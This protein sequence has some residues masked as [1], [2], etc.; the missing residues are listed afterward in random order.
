MVFIKVYLIAHMKTHLLT[1]PSSIALAI[2]AVFWG[3][4][5]Q[6]TAPDSDSASFSATPDAVVVL[7]WEEYI[8][9]EVMDLYAEESGRKVDYQIYESTDELR[10][11]LES[12]PGSYD[13]VIADESTRRELNELQLLRKFD[14]GLLDQTKNLGSRFWADEHKETN[15]HSVP[16][17]WGSTIIAYRTDKLNLT[18]EDFSWDLFWDPRLRGKCAMIDEK[19]DIFAIGLIKHG[20]SPNSNDEAELRI[21]QK[22]L[23]TATGANAIQFGGCWE[24]LER[25]SDGEIWATHCYSGDAA[26]FASENENIAYF[27]PNEGAQLWKDE[28][29]VPRD[30]TQPEAAHDFINFMLRADVAALNAN[31]L[32]YLTPND[33]ALSMLDEELLADEVLNPSEAM[34]EKCEFIHPA[35]ATRERAMQLG[36]RE[37]K[38]A[39]EKALQAIAAEPDPA[40]KTAM[41]S[42]AR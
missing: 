12:N 31:T 34:L 10:A 39:A 26:Y 21:A 15:P 32:W 14:F 19:V 24:N 1:S 37:I 35:T 23:A 11:L 5:K 8:A 29:I 7:G 17:L 3:G 22:S 41:A 2:A 13:I 18:D 9:P 36:M 38:A 27:M 6:E 16:Y 42:D 40:S 20:F 30:C 28:L 25:L 4:C 33:A